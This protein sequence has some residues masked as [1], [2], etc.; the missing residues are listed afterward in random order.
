[1]SFDEV[2]RSIA[3]FM[4]RWGIWSLRVSMGVIFIWFGILKPLGISPAEPLVLAT[5]QWLPV[6]EPRGWLMVIGWWEVLIGASFLFHRTLRL[7]IGLLVLQLGGT[8]LPLVVLPEVA[9]Q[10]G[11]APWAPTMEG[12]YI[13]KNLLIVSAALVVGGTV[14]RREARRP[15]SAG[16]SGR[17]SPAA[18]DVS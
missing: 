18:T 14:R 7:A 17:P 3:S 15:V 5:V 9:F 16:R 4:D 12:Q 11:R 10:A 8:F 2:D 13:I 1:M 6:L